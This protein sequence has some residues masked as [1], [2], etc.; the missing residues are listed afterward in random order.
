VL[1]RGD[2]WDVLAASGTGL[3]I[4]D[5]GPVAVAHALRDALGRLLAGELVLR[6]DEDFIARYDARAQAAQLARWLR[7]LAGRPED[8]PAAA[9]P[10]PLGTAA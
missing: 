8:G 10:A 4:E 6:P 2:A 1:P 5:T 7:R 9:A 3:P